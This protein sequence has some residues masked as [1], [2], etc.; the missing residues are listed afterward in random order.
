M[1]TTVAATVLLVA[2]PAGAGAFT[3]SNDTPFPS[4]PVISGAHWIGPRHN[5]PGN[6]FGDILPTSWADDN[7]N[8]VLMDDGGTGAPANG[9]LWRNSLARIA[10]FPQR[11]LTFSRI[12]TNPAPA[13]WSQIHRDS[14]RWTGPLGS[15]YSTGFTTVRHVFYATQVENWPWNSNGWFDGLAGIAYST[16][17]GGHWHFPG[18]P[19]LGPIGNLN[20]VQWGRNATAGDGYVYA[21]GTEREFNATNLIL[22][23][24]RPD[25]SDMTNPARWQWASG[26]LPFVGGSW[27]EWSGSSASAQP[28]LTWAQHITYPRMSYDAPLHRYLLTFTYSYAA[29]P[30]AIWKDGS[31]LVVLDAPHPW[32]PFSFVARNDFF[33]PSNGYDPEFPVKWISSNGLDLW[34]IWA[35]NFDGCGAGL[36]CAGGYGF[37]YQEVGL[38][39]ARHGHRAHAATVPRTL[40]QAAPRP[41]RQWRGLPATPPR[42]VL[43]RLLTA[44]PSGGQ[45]TNRAAGHD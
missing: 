31:A 33:G 32:G 4:S 34:L 28:I 17:H 10:G 12:G 39:L 20:W 26:W 11:K 38:S 13:T 15:Y 23:R 25:I 36:S 41:P 16:D 22:G 35:A 1:W 45:S 19:F 42:F 44:S 37:N 6:Q 21:I 30:P 9:A 5:P 18:M 3:S 14:T 2:F 40:A 8:Y 24:S 29:K 27:P 7:Y 43:P